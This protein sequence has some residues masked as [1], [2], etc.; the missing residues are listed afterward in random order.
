MNLVCLKKVLIFCFLSELNIFFPKRNLY[1]KLLEILLKKIASIDAFSDFD[2][3]LTDGFRESS[4]PLL[5]DIL[6]IILEKCPKIPTQ[7]LNL[8][9]VNPHLSKL[10]T[11]KIKQQIWLHNP[12]LFVKELNLL[13]NEAISNDQ[14]FYRQ[15]TITNPFSKNC[16]L[17]PNQDKICQKIASYIS[18]RFIL[19]ETA[20]N[21]IVQAYEQSNQDSIYSLI[22]FSLSY[23]IVK[24]ENDD[25]SVISDDVSLNLIRCLIKPA[26]KDKAGSL[27]P[28]SLK[29]LTKCID[30]I[31]PDDSK[32]LK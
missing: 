16:N 18:D 23:F 8:I 2:S 7:Y 1:S 25:S 9:I 13:F 6:L 24:R 32:S 3:I 17:L 30:E 5:T 10:C 31:N 22:L 4:N 19:Y 20:I 11:L 26:S 21:L 28:E 27:T 15:L 29:E 14:D 12:T